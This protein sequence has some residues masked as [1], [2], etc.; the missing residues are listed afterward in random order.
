LKVDNTCGG[1][2]WAR[3][4]RRSTRAQAQPVYEGIQ[5]GGGKAPGIGR[6]AGNAVGGRTGYRRN[7]LHKWREQMRS[8]GPEKVFRGPGA[9][10]LSEESLQAIRRELSESK[11]S[12]TNYSG[13]K[14]TSRDVVDGGVTA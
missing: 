3:Q 5:T 13:R 1:V 10:P 8:K 12:E 2:R 4:S 6:E 11:G 14:K 9:K 7:Q